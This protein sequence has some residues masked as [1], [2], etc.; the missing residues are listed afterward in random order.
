MNLLLNCFLPLP[1]RVGQH[2]APDYY[3]HIEISCQCVRETASHITVLSIIHLDKHQFEILLPIELKND[4][5]LLFH[6]G[7][8]DKT[9]ISYLY[10]AL[11][12][13]E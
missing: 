7:T 8:M 1:K 12:I 3:T 2:M 5:L 4:N 13:W 9:L 10:F 11:E 6:C